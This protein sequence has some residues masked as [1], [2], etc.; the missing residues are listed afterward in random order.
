[1]VAEAMTIQQEATVFV[2][3]DDPAIRKSLRW[4]IESVGLKVQTHELASEFLESYSP[5]HPGCLVLDVRIPGM[6]GL[7]LQEKLRERGYDIPVIIVSGYGDVPM[8][9]RAMK[10][11]AVDFLEKPVSDQVLLDYIQKGIERDI[12]NK[13]NR[14]QNKEL[15]ERKATLTRR[16][17]E[18]MKYVVSGFSSREIAEKLNVSFKTV[19]AH[20]AKI[21]KKMQAKSVPKLIQMELQ[22]Q[23]S[24]TPTQER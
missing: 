11:G 13:A 14:E 20:R 18:V 4:L 3:D 5:D 2:V 22:I 12:Q 16:E 19:E 10:A 17:N 15:V 23:G 8:A 21:M 7:E 9:V 6:S 1:M 24:P